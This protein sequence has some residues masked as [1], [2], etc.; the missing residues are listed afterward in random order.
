MLE[1]FGVALL[2]D[3]GDT[4]VAELPPRPRQIA[5][6]EGDDPYARR[7]QRL[8]RQSEG[9]E[10]GRLITRFDDVRGLVTKRGARS[11]FM[12]DKSIGFHTAGLSAVMHELAP[13]LYQSR[14]R[15]GGEAWLYVISGRGHSEVDGEIHP[16]EAG[17]LIVID[18]WQMH[19]HFN[20][21]LENTAR[22][23]RV[24]NFDALYDMMRILLDPLNLFEELPTLDAPDL[25]SVVWPDHLAGRPDA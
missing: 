7:T 5:A 22:L 9:E 20:D 21:D 12:V 3:G 11:L 25:S 13:G 24:H 19:Q 18:H 17:D 14:H 16:W 6:L 23:V 10:A 4:P 2:E 15:H 8:A 1:Q